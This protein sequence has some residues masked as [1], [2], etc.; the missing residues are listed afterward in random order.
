MESLALPRGSLEVYQLALN[1]I[2]RRV[3]NSRLVTLYQS[4]MLSRGD[5][6]TESK[7]AFSGML[8]PAKHQHGGNASCFLRVAASASPRAGH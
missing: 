7:I 2:L 3:L 8:P 6:N 5:R 4:G 1:L